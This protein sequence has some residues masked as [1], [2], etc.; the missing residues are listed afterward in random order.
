M[1]KRLVEMATGTMPESW[2]NLAAGPSV[3]MIVIIIYSVWTSLGYNIVI[4]LAGLT[5]IP[6]EPMEA[7]RIDGAG[8]WTILRRIIWPLVT[9]VTFFLLIANT[10]G[11]FQAFD[12]IYVLTRS[13]LWPWRC[14][15]TIGDHAHRNSLH[16]SQLLRTGQCCWLCRGGCTLL[17]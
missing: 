12:P 1:A 14:G 11:A 6:N 4:Y 3:A 17:F 5:S 9:P 13:G 15:R 2:P 10:I 16:L 7:A 8:D